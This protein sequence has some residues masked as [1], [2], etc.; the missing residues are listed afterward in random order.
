MKLN[1]VN[2]MND[3][4]GAMTFLAS[5]CATMNEGEITNV[6]VKKEEGHITLLCHSK[7]D[8]GKVLPVFSANASIDTIE[9]IS[10]KAL[11]VAS[12]FIR[13][14]AVV[15][16]KEGVATTE[17]KKPVAKA[18]AKTEKAKPSELELT[19]TKE[20]KEPISANEDFD[21]EEPFEVDEAIPSGKKLTIKEI[22]DASPNVIIAKP[23]MG[24]AEP[25][26]N[27]PVLDEDDF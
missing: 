24:T 25:K 27:I 6:I 7:N 5:L 26:K 17:E 22:A 15:I 16:Q 4:V 18:K 11:A 10:I 2:A 12:G 14:T 23:D 8:K 20:P 1:E 9:A 13:D 19:E 3:N 21:D